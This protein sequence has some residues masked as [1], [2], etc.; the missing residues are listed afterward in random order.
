MQIMNL[1]FRE[2]RYRLVNCTLAVFAIVIAVG[3]LL[4]SVSILNVHELY[5]AAILSRKEAETQQKLAVL[6]DEM[7]KATLKLGFN[8]LILPEN[9]NLRDWH[10]DDYASEYMPEEYVSR[11]ANSGIMTVR[12]FLP[13]LPRPLD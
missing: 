6:N 10:A 4:C 3:S 5:T 2:L 12:H 8:L 7:R 13:S 11:L 9:L 1:L